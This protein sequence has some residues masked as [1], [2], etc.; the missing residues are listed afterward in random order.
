MLVKGI[1]GH[2]SVGTYL[3]SRITRITQGHSRCDYYLET[4]TSRLGITAWTW[5][6]LFIMTWYQGLGRGGGWIGP[7]TS[8]YRQRWS[9]VAVGAR[10]QV[11]VQAWQNSIFRINL[12]HAMHGHRSRL[13]KV[14]CLNVYVLFQIWFVVEPK[15]IAISIWKRDL[16]N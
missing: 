10:T 12:I 16:Y 6:L 2:A 3:Q 5:R 1:P 11:Q 7:H 9:L 13:A 14:V 15:T 4:R 8:I